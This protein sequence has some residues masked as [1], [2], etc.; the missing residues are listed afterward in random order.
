MTRFTE[1]T[2]DSAYL[3]TIAT[4]YAEK[5]VTVDDKKYVLYV[6]DTCG[7]ERFKSLTQNF[8]RGT[9]ICLLTFALD[10]YASFCNLSN[11][12]EEFLHFSGVDRALQ[13]P[14]IV[15]GN[16]A[17]LPHEQR[18]VKSI[19][20]QAWCENG[21]HGDIPYIEASA[22]TGQNVEEL[23]LTAVKRLVEAERQNVNPFLDSGRKGPSVINDV[24][25]E[26]AK[27]KEEEKQRALEAAKTQVLNCPMCGKVLKTNSSRKS[28]LKNCAAKLGVGTE[29]L[30]EIVKRQKEEH[31]VKIAAGILPVS[32]R[33]TMMIVMSYL[34]CHQCLLADEESGEVNLTDWSPDCVLTVLRFVYAGLVDTDPD[35]L[36]GTLS[37]ANRN[38]PASFSSDDEIQMLELDENQATNVTVHHDV[39]TFSAEKSGEAA[40]EIKDAGLTEG[41]KNTDTDAGPSP[42]PACVDDVW[43]GFEDMDA[44]NPDILLDLDPDD[45]G[46]VDFIVCLNLLYT[47]FRLVEGDVDFIVCLNLLYTLFRLVEGDVDF[48][49]CLNLLYTLFCLVEGC[50]SRHSKGAAT[51]TQDK[52]RHRSLGPTL[53]FHT[54]ASL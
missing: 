32:S 33:T 8:Y 26:A 9:Q 48:I 37:L 25:D 41:E 22:K 34:R 30:L 28:H 50:A 52:K 12:R 47:L 27:Q 51:S 53:T 11:W 6:V 46:D 21:G 23:F 1:G 18:V 5:E 10:D 44:Y 16:K 45:K 2:F 36:P 14:F 38:S 7:A 42:D 49:V 39:R 24:Q 43:E 29:Q 31:E 3:A 20:A 15:V 19:S 4:E 54:D 13:F 17:D 40:S 35:V